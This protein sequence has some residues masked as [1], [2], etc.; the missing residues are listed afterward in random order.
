MLTFLSRTYDVLGRSRA[1]RSLMRAV[2]LRHFAR[3]W[4]RSAVLRQELLRPDDV[5]VLVGIRNRCDY[6]I[7]N[8]LRSIREQTYPTDLVHIIV[9]DYGSDPKSA[10][11][12]VD[13]CREH[14]AE[15]VRVDEA[16]VWSRARCLNVGI[17]RTTT[18]FLLTSDADI[19]LS[20]RYLSD[21]VRALRRS[22][23]SVVCSPMLDLP[24]ESIDALRRA[25]E[26]DE[27]LQSEEWRGRCSARFGWALHPSIAVALTAFFA[28]IRG[29][30]EYYEGWGAEDDDLM[31]RFRYLGLDPIGSGSES[32]YLHQWHPKFEGLS[33]QG[34]RKYVLRNRAYFETHHSILR[35]P[36][37]W[38]TSVRS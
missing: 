37:E 20:P 13:A 2:G 29:Y 23:L 7:A 17:R 30:D 22:P 21:A 15:Y 19:V 33:E 31:R 8:T 14:D 10:R 27:G 4:L 38:G 3:A 35:N 5:T 11:L 32:F 28:I 6:R 26:S 1:A 25:A 9:V 18:K 36:G 16:P 34:H 12:T 24:E